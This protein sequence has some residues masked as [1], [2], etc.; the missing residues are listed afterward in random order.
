[1]ADTAEQ[2]EDRN[3]RRQEAVRRYAGDDLCWKDLRHMG[4]VRYGQVLADLAD[5]GLKYPVAPLEGKN[6]DLRRRGIAWL[7]EAIDEAQA[8]R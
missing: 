6:E 2:T 1:M 3:N 8:H 4:I 7:E 5:M